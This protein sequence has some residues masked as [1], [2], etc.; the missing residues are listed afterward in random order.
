MNDE[1]I[2]GYRLGKVFQEVVREYLLRLS[3]EDRSF[4]RTIQENSD[5]DRKGEREWQLIG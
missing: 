2:E 5:K 1:F 3:P 4:S